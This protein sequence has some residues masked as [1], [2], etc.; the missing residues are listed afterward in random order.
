MPYWYDEI[1]T[2][3]FA[4]MQASDALLLGRKTYQGFAGAFPSGPRA[5]PLLIT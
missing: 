5:I 1:G 2:E 4:S 3:I